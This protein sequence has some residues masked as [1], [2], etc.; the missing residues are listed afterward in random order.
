M[1]FYDPAHHVLESV[2]LNLGELRRGAD[3]PER[4]PGTQPPPFDSWFEVDV[5]L[6]LVS[7]GYRVL[8]QYKAGRH[9]IDLVVEGRTRL[10]IECD[11]D[12]WHGPEQFD[13]DMARQRQLERAKWR[14]WRLRA[15]A[16]YGDP[17]SA[18]APLW[19]LLGELGIEPMPALDGSGSSE[20]YVPMV[21]TTTTKESDS[22]TSS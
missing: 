5:Y 4:G 19:S 20:G 17:D 10:A 18:L 7:R 2:G 14:F 21:D 11:G 13:Q 16:F 6:R 22:I 1:Y 15:S 3:A 9:R 12:T 8:P